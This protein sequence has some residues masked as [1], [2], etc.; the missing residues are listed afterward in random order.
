MSKDSSFSSDGPVLAD[1]VPID[2]HELRALLDEGGSAA[3]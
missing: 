3:L 2:L 1:T